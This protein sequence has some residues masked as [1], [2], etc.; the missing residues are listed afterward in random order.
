L[1]QGQAEIPVKFLSRTSGATVLLTPN[2]AVLSLSKPAAAVRMQLVEANPAPAIS[3]VDE[4]PGKSNYFMG[5]DPEKWR[6]NVSTFGK[7][8]YGSIYPGIDLIYY[9][10]HRQLEYDFV[11]NPGA[12]PQTIRFNLKGADDLELDAQ[13]DLVLHMAGG[14]VRQHKPI[15]YQEVNGIRHELSG[16]YVLNDSREVTFQIAEYD[17]RQQLIIDPVVSYATYFGGSDIDIPLAG[18]AADSNG[19]AYIAG[20]TSSTNFPRTA[21]LQ[22]SFGGGN[23]VFFGEEGQP[24]PP[25]DMFVTKI[26]AAG[27]AVLYSTYLGGSGDDGATGIA[28]DAAGNAYV[29]GVTT[30]T[31]FPVTT[32][33]F[34]TTKAFD[35]ETT[36]TKINSTGSALVYSTYLGG[37]GEGEPDIAVDSAGNAYVVGGTNGQDFPVTAGAYQTT[38]PPTAAGAQDGDGFITKFNAA[39]SALLYSTYLG[40]NSRDSINGIVVDDSGNAYVTGQTQSTNFPTTAGAYQS[41]LSGNQ[42]ANGPR[43]QD[44]FVTKINAAGS[45]LIYSTYLGG[46]NRDGTVG[47]GI[48]G[49]GNAYVAGATESTTFPT[50]AGAVQRTYGGGVPEGCGF[51]IGL[52][53][54]GDA[55]VT[56]L[57]ATGTALVYSTYLGGSKGD[58]ASRIRVTSGGAAYIVGSTLSANFPTK[59][60]V[61]AANASATGTC[62]ECAD[63][64]ITNLD[65]SGAL[66]YS[67]YYGGT[68]TTQT[69]DS[70]GDDRGLGIA[71]DNTGI[72]YV[73]GIAQSNS[74]PTVNPIQPARAGELDAF[75]LKITGGTI[76]D[77]SNPPPPPPPVEPPGG[78][79]A[80]NTSSYSIQ[81]YGA[82][83][84]TSSGTSASVSAGYAVIQPNAG[85]SA[86]SGVAI[87]GFRQNNILVSEAGVPVSALIQSGRIYAEV[88]GPVNT[89]L[90]IAN[91]NS[92]AATI[93]FYFKDQSS[94][95]T[96]FGA[97]TAT[98]P[99]NGQIAAFLNQ[100]PFNGGSSL[101]GTFTF[102]SNVPVAVVALRGLTN[103]R[104][105]FLLTT[106]PVS[107]LTAATGEIAYFPHFADGGGWSTQVVLV[108]PTDEVLAG[109]VQ[110][111]GQGTTS[112][113]A[114]PVSV[115]IG[116]QVSSS[117]SYTIPA[118]SS[119][120]LQTAG[121]MSAVRAGSVR[122]TPSAGGKTPSGLAIFSFRNGG[123]T[124][125]EAGVS[126]ARTGLAFRLYAEVSDAA[127]GSIQTGIAITNP[128]AVNVSVSF[129][130]HSLS[131]APTGITG[132]YI[133]PANG[134]VALFLNQLPGFG[135]LTAP[136]QGVLRISTGSV[137]GISVV[138][139]R[140]RTN[141][142]GDFLITTTPPVDEAGPS[143]NGT[144]LFPHLADGGGYTTQFVLFSGLAGQTSSG[145]LRFYAQNG[146]VLN[147]TLR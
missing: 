13:G 118:R 104:S 22:P 28:V 49:F 114:Q 123:V 4:L 14:D 68:S 1:N 69:S 58:F 97:G 72:A 100:S 111:L 89:G 99:P 131:G 86:P 103:E 73:T 63:A 67:T 117:F 6:T 7:V 45:A 39:G 31:N 38:R 66:Y 80:T 47:I 40:G 143:V 34:K 30:S 146:N 35:F 21:A 15:V 12:D 11:V 53:I 124:V 130:L 60:P 82:V 24:G 135:A 93:S 20:L 41:S 46:N 112:A 64:F 145:T 23:G 110:F 16:G 105:E 56:K 121:N 115:S 19:N 84:Q 48:D 88:N 134:Q 29:T 96:N 42:V 3:G 116:T 109:T 9:G 71:I 85:S 10:N 102:S 144:L 43:P 17:R 65:S 54:C 37:V 83:S 126:A 120:K 98:V 147:L 95:G 18:I 140:G 27:S 57:N 92:Q 5:S 136:F 94:A 26:N 32:G 55:F 2:E 61:Q 78:G 139:L 138:G 75:F 70:G 74:F 36:V 107:P 51:D 142:R 33:A 101:S 125:A 106:L 76:G 113:P 133:V 25:F 119:T 81:N 44:A 137:T 59:D 141:E 62:T 87:F 50:T 77:G 127:S 8:R 91:P 52:D 122:V 129:E 128:A 79:T 108:N 132:S 90:A